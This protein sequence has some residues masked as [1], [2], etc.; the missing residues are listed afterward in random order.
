MAI[1]D[2]GAGVAIA[3]KEVWDAWG[4]PALRKT[5]MKLQL[6]DGYIESPTSL[7]EKVIVTSCEIEYEH[8]FA[9]VDFGKKPNYKI[10]L[11]RPFM[12][13]LKMIQDWGYNY[14]Y[15]RHPNATTRIDLQD[16]SYKDVLNTPVRDMVSTIAHEESVPLWLV[17]GRPLW[18]SEAGNEGEEGSDASSLNYIPEPFPEEEFKSHGWP[19]ILAT[20]DVC[21]NVH[22]TKHCDDEGYDLISMNMVNFILMEEIDEIIPEVEKTLRS[23]YSSSYDEEIILEGSQVDMSRISQ[24]PMR[25][26]EVLVPCQPLLRMEISLDSGFETPRMETLEQERK[27]ETLEEENKEFHDA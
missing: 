6:A 24:R 21:A 12:R 17:N 22:A 5:R 18:L 4:N 23:D 25:V 27:H 8:T 19:D 11:G 1:L 26:E 13:Q 16:H 2:S 3:T 14:I 10:I 15:L 9:V 20:L 7:L